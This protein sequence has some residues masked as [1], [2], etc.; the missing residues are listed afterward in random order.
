[1]VSLPA[2]P[3]TS[4]RLVL[5][6]VG[7]PPVIGTAPPLTRMVPSATRLIVMLLPSP[8]PTTVSTP[9]LKLAVTAISPGPFQ[10]DSL[11]ESTQE[12][13]EV[14]PN[15]GATRRNVS[16]LVQAILLGGHRHPET[17]RLLLVDRKIRR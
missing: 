13:G 7:V 16:T 8:S 12:T 6:T 15:L 4:I 1:M 10:R 3:K 9:A 2:W 5:A 17:C 14:G 11:R